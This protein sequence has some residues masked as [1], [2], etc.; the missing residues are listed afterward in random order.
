M[1]PEKKSSLRAFEDAAKAILSPPTEGTDESNSRQMVT[2]GEG[3]NKDGTLVRAVGDHSSSDPPAELSAS[4]KVVDGIDSNTLNYREVRKSGDAST[5][6]LHLNGRPIISPE[7]SS[8]ALTVSAALSPGK[9]VIMPQ[10]EGPNST[11]GEIVIRADPYTV[12]GSHALRKRVPDGVLSR[13]T[14]AE[15]AANVMASND[16]AELAGLVV[17]LGKQVSGLRSML[18]T[19]IE[20]KKRWEQHAEGLQQRYFASIEELRQDITH[21]KSNMVAENRRL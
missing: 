21:F 19:E 10:D 13:T 5:R 11:K 6:S 9:T 2:F 7:T 20:G 12:H 18:S 1:I 16:A 3:V 4:S 15:S 14:G 8:K 17:D